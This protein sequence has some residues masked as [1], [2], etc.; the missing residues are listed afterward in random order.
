MLAEPSR[1]SVGTV[2]FA[3]ALDGHRVVAHDP[4]VV[5]EGVRERFLARPPRLALGVGHELRGHAHDLGHEVLGGVAASTLGHHRLVLLDLIGRRPRRRIDDVGRLPERELGHRR[6]RRSREQG[7]GGARGRAPQ[8]GRAT[9]R[10]DDRL[11]V[12]DLALDGIGQRVARVAATTTVEVEDAEVRGQDGR[13]AGI[14]AAI[15][16]AAADEDDGRPVTLI[17]RWRS[18]SR[19][20]RSR[21]GGWC[22]SVGSFRVR[23]RSS[24][25]GQAAPTSAKASLSHV[26]Q[27]AC[28]A[29]G[30]RSA[31]MWWPMAVPPMA[32][33]KRYIPSSVRTPRKSVVW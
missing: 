11:D 2:T 9:S 25:G 15:D 32:A 8:P 14:G 29:A 22:S 10:R 21:A 23:R 18:R 26:S 31:K 6:A 12:L 13:H 5:G 30:S 16:G 20:R 17:A 7:Q 27:A 33:M 1:T 19:R 28:V 4:G 24:S 3:A